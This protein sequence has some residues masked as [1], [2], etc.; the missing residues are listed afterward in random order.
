MQS[1]NGILNMLKHG[2]LALQIGERVYSRNLWLG[3]V[4]MLDLATRSMPIRGR[5]VGGL[6]PRRL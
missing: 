1:R 3:E 2:K 4:R 6:S 5:R